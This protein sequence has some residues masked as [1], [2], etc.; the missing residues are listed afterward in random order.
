DIV[1]LPEM[2]SPLKE[3]CADFIRYRSP[4][5]IGFAGSNCDYQSLVIE[6]QL[7][8]IEGASVVSAEAVKNAY[9]ITVAKHDSVRDFLSASVFMAGS[10][11]RK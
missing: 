6:R 5:I 7:R 2:S 1:S 11:R 4:I 9:R 3:F 10:K 8:S